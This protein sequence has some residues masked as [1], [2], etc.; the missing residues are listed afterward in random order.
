[1]NGYPLY[2]RLDGPQSRSGRV[3]KIS[4]LPE[5]DTRAVQPV[6]SRY[7]DYAIP[8]YQNLCCPKNSITIKHDTNVYHK[9]TAIVQSLSIQTISPLNETFR[10]QICGPRRVWRLS[11]EPCAIKGCSTP[12]YVAGYRSRLATRYG[13]DGPGIEFR[14]EARFSVPVQTGPEAHPASCIMVPGIFPGSVVAG[15]LRWPAPALPSGEVKETLE[16][17]LYSPSGSSWPV[18]TWNLSLSTVI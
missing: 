16:L 11:N 2:R 14:W 10:T 3:R 1:M 6:A 9:L 7:T 15:V 5:F 18:L 12:T 8:A 13:L 17:Y 4:S